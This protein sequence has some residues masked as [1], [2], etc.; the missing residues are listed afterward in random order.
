MKK[1]LC[2]YFDPW[3]NMIVKLKQELIKKTELKGV[4]S[5]V[6]PELWIK[7]ENVLD[8]IQEK[9]L[10]DVQSIQSKRTIRR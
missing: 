3:S 10:D 5:L 1:N 8:P 4:R 9:I 6:L 7:I 2:R